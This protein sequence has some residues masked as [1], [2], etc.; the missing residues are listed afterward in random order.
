MEARTMHYINETDVKRAVELGMKLRV[1]LGNAHIPQHIAW[2]AMQGVIVELFEES[3]G[4][5]A[6]LKLNDALVEEL[7]EANENKNKH[8]TR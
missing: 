8:E 4:A 7:K 2:L 5:Q 3:F 1:A 6:A